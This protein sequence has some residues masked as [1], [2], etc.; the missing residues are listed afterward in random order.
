MTQRI[1][2]VASVVLCTLIGLSPISL[3]AP[4]RYPSPSGKIEITFEPPLPIES[5]DPDIP[6]ASSQ[7]RRI[8]YQF[9]AYP[10]GSGTAIA[11]AEYYDVFGTSGTSKPSTGAELIKA[12]AWSPH[13]RFVILPP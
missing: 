13:E 5:A 11:T 1:V 9:A 3:S 7:I 8:R 2:V 12:L 4:L 10:R 6:Q